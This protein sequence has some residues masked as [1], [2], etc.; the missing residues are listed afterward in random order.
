MFLQI[1]AVQSRGE[2]STTLDEDVKFKV[3]G[4][5]SKEYFFEYTCILGPET[6]YVSLK[7]NYEIA[8][9]RQHIIHIIL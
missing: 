9:S 5:S 1:S 4:I 8:V 2:R 7:R 3:C 6:I